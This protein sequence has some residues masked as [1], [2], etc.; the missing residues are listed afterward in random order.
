MASCGPVKYIVHDVLFPSPKKIKLQ[1][2]RKIISPSNQ[3]SKRISPSVFFITLS[4]IFSETIAKNLSKVTSSNV[5]SNNINSNKQS[6]T[7]IL[8]QTSHY[9]EM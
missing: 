2:K 9:N 1:E 8:S 3:E 7:I 4:V 5:A 6:L